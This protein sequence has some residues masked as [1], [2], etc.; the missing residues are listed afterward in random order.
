[1]VVSG[2][3]IDVAAFKK[4]PSHLFQ[5]LGN[6]PSYAAFVRE[7]LQI[8][9]FC[10]TDDGISLICDEDEET[11][12]EFYR[13]YRHIKRVWPTAKDKLAGITFA[14]DTQL[15][16]LQAADMVA[17]LIR[18][19]AGRRMLALPYDY[20]DLFQDL[21]AATAKP[22]ERIWQSEIAFADENTMVQLAT[23]LKGEWDRR[24][25]RKEKPNSE[26]PKFEN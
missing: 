3:A 19:E 24:E 18:L 8:I 4:Q 7:I 14:D 15:F 22:G 10:G 1:L 26:Y 13:L 9:D 6:D 12:M 23:D 20:G 11:A 25:I 17:S 5:K 16:A 21:T 2:V